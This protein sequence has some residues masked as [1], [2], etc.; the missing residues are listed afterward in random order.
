MVIGSEEA[1]AHDLVENC[2][3]VCDIESSG[4]EQS[5]SSDDGKRSW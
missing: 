2:I 5:E 1:K 4:P 3:W